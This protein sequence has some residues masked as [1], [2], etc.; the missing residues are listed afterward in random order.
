MGK[1]DACVAVE[2]GWS[3]GAVSAKHPW[4]RAKGLIAAQSSQEDFMIGT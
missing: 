4:S 3:L 2:P 1:A